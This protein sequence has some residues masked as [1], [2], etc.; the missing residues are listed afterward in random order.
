MVDVDI[1]ISL[2][3]TQVLLY[4]V[5]SLSDSNTKYSK[6]Y[7]FKMLDFLIDNMFVVNCCLVFFNRELVDIPIGTT[8]DCTPIIV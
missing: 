2:G 5:E 4:F 1:N 3:V 6:S 7:F 8:C